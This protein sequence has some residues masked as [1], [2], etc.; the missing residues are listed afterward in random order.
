M[1]EV[2]PEKEKKGC[3]FHYGKAI[4]TQLQNLG[5]AVAYRQQA[6]VNRWF[7]RIRALCI[8]PEY[9]V[10]QVATDLLWPTDGQRGNL[11]PLNMDQDTERAMVLFSNYFVRFWLQVIFFIFYLSIQTL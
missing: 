3:T 2:I 4:N 11:F 6:E 7:R 5:L 1:Q 9:L 10:R 8:C